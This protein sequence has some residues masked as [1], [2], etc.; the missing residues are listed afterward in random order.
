M[1]DYMNR[2]DRENHLLMLILWERLT[3]WLDA[4][5][6]LSAEERKR[7]KTAA[8]HLL[9]A[10]DSLIHRMGTEYARQLDRDLMSKHVE[11]NN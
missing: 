1:K 9:K 11:V 8:T 7:A 4:T 3:T 5:T 2:N 10:S 6:C